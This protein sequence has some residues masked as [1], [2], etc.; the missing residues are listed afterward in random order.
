MAKGLR[1]AE[2]FESPSAIYVSYIEYAE[3]QLLTSSRLNGTSLTSFWTGVLTISMARKRGAIHMPAGIENL[4]AFKE[5]FPT[6]FGLVKEEQ[7]SGPIPCLW[8]HPSWLMHKGNQPVVLID[9][10]YEQAQKMHPLCD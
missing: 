2:A 8:A 9:I 7:D 4:D 6:A 5:M 3:G 10:F 1:L